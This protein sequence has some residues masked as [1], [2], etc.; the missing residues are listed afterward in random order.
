MNRRADTLEIAIIPQTIHVNPRRV[1][2]MRIRATEIL[3][4]MG[5][6]HVAYINSAMK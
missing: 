4:L 6:V 3:H 2:A 5:T 1:P